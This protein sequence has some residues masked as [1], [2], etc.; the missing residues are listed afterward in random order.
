[1]VILK[2]IIAPI[3]EIEHPGLEV[4]FNIKFDRTGNP[5]TNIENIIWFSCSYALDFTANTCNNNNKKHKSLFT[6]EKNAKVKS[7]VNSI[8]SRFLKFASRCLK[9]YLQTG[10]NVYTKSWGF[11]FV[12]RQQH[13][14]R[15]RNYFNANFIIILEIY[16]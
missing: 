4:F 5:N 14:C 8:P 11:R 7:F 15:Y 9:I 1:M 2:Y 6:N 10:L 16:K 3:Q 12:T 13:E